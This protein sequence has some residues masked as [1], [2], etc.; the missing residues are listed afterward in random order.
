MKP[1]ADSIAP[2]RDFVAAV[3]KLADHFD[4]P[5][6]IT[7]VGDL[8]KTL[9][10]QDDWLPQAYAQPHPTY[11]Q[12]YLLHC[13]PL[14]RF[15]IVSF[16][17]GPGQRTPVHD[18]GVWG[19]IGVLRGAERAQ[20]Y[21]ADGNGRL[22]PLGDFETLKQGEIDFVSPQSGDWH[23]VENALPDRP[24]ISIHIYGANIGAVRRRVYDPSSGQE[25]P[26]VSGYSL[27]FV[28][29]LWDRSHAVRAS[30]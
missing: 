2:L 6:T 11:Y 15:S 30:A 16:V 5:A 14:E 21:G 27:D 23:I 3:T 24:S 29:N 13:D 7:E 19:F 12:Q 22:V 26:F 9:I 17:W 8:L 1:S 18:H 25:K 28:P 10:A 4:A 20:R